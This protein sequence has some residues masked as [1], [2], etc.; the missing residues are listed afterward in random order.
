MQGD[1]NEITFDFAFSD[2][3]MRKTDGSFKRINKIVSFEYPYPEEWTIVT[4]LTIVSEIGMAILSLNFNNKREVIVSAYESSDSD[5]YYAPY[6]P[7]LSEWSQQK[8]WLVPEPTQ[9]LIEQD[10][11]FWKYLYNTNIIDSRYL[12][13]IYGKRDTLKPDAWEELEEQTDDESD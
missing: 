6:I 11:E 8:G 5:G 12:E 9:F 7:A 1:Y 2:E 10:I 4:N 3:I 13:K